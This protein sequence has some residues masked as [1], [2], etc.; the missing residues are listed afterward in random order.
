[1]HGNARTATP[2]WGAT[3]IGDYLGL[4]ERQALHFLEQGR[5]PARRQGRFWQSTTEELDAYLRGESGLNLPPPTPG[6]AA[7]LRKSV[8]RKPRPRVGSAA[9][10]PA[11]QST[12]AE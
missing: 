2:I 3:P 9:R 4:S 12:A 7:I 10:E 5:I 11:P 1:M 6:K 8:K